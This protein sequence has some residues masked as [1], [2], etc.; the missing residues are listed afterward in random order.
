VPGEGCLVGRE[1]AWGRLHEWFAA[2][3]QGTR[4]IGFISGEAGLG[5]TTLVESFVSEFAAAGEAV[6]IGRGQSV[7]HYGA[8]EAYLPVLEALS[9]LGRTASCPLRDVLRD[10]APGWLTHLPALNFGPDAPLAPRVT[11]ARMLRELAEA[12]EIFTVTEPLVLIL[13]DLHWS[14]SATLEWLGYVARRRD[15]ARLL[16]VGTYRPVEVLLLDHPLRSLIA[17]LRRQPQCD[18][19]T[20]DYLP[21]AAVEAYVRQ[22]CGNITVLDTLSATL[23]RRTGGHPLFLSAIVNELSSRVATY[24]A[25]EEAPLGPE[26][27]AN[28]LPTSV[29][30]FIEH[31]FS[32]LSNDEQVMVEA[33]SVAGDPF[34]VAAVMA[35]TEWPEDPVDGCLAQWTRTGGFLVGD[36]GVLARR[37]GDRGVSLS[38]RT[39]SGGRL[40]PHCSR[41]AGPISPSDRQSSRAWLRGSRAP[42]GRRARP[43]LR[44][45]SRPEGR[46]DLARAGR[47]QRAAAL[48]V[49]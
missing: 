15:P 2:A 31:R 46:P 48:G 9:R 6:R 4:R 5:K 30:Q 19:L 34:S 21:G 13:E 26:A 11:P 8:G 10:H 49:P 36:D 44:A 17:E 47:A 22:R 14:D 3:A 33:A 18:E 45:G 20:L 24:P 35:A 7:E 40:R 38:T 28:E 39:L 41:A 1:E 27:A 29:R 43:A 25:G 12:L 42:A 23:H 32:Q 37:H 16:V